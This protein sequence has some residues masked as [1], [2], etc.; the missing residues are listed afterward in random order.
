MDGQVLHIW[1]HAWEIEDLALWPMFE[2]MLGLVAEAAMPCMTNGQV[3][4]GNVL[5]ATTAGAVT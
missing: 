3:A 1:G 5:P 4:S 2:E